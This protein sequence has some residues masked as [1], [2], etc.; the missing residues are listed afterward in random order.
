M[1]EINKTI[2]DMKMGMEAIKKTWTEGILK[3]KNLGKRSGIKD[4]SITIKI[5]EIEERFVGVEDKIKEIDTSV[6]EMLN[7]IF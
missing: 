6:K 7:Y 5:R 4:T 1:K 3:M 2:Q